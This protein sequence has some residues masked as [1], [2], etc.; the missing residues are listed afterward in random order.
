MIKSQGLDTCVTDPIL[1]FA[2]TLLLNVH[3]V[4]HHLGFYHAPQFSTECITHV[5]SGSRNSEPQFLHYYYFQK[6]LL[7]PYQHYSTFLKC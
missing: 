5:V 7:S 4:S 1:I 6:V 3:S 2:F